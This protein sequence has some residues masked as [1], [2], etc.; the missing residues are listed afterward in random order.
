VESFIASLN[1]HI[2]VS[3]PSVC[4]LPF[5]HDILSNC[6]IIFVHSFAELNTSISGLYSFGLK[7][8]G[9][10]VVVLCNNINLDLSFAYLI[11]LN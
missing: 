5:L 2:W 1:L 8:T 9:Y 6:N 3:I 10:F 4:F 7:D 11:F